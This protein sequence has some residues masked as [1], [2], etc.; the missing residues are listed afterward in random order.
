MS[1]TQKQTV[2][3]WSSGSLEIYEISTEPIAEITPTSGDEY[4]GQPAENPLDE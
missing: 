2:H 4:I 1:K 3:D